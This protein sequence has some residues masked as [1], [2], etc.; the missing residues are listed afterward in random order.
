MSGLPLPGPQKRYIAHAGF[1]TTPRYLV[2]HEQRR[3][4]TP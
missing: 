1:V 3:R 2:L 4:M